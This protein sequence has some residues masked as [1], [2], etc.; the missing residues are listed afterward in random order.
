MAKPRNDFRDRMQLLAVRFV[1]MVMYCWPVEWSLAVAGFCGSVYY[2]LVRKHRDRAFENLRASYPEKSDR[3]LRKVAHESIRQMFQFGVE[4]IFTPRLVRLETWGRYVELSEFRETLD[5]MLRN[6]RGL[7]LLTGHY[8]NWEVLGYVLATLG[9]ATT[10]VA[11]PLDNPY[12][13]E[14]VFGVRERMGQK[15]VA[16]KGMTETVTEALANG[17]MVGFTADQDAGKKGL[18]VDFFGRKASAYKSIALLAMQYD[19]PIVIGSARRM[20]GKYRFICET[21]DIIRPEQWKTQ[22]DPLTYITQR[23]TSAIEKAVR[24]DPSQYLWV[25]RRW[26]TRPKEELRAAAK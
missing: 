5:L 26:K 20:R 18:F 9:F 11:R 1:S 2:Q 6:R 21:S 14:Y 12:L 16:K 4:F 19:I 7:I 8:G 24:V 10:S 3:E 25:H 22:D 15:I 17:E 13:S 23:Y